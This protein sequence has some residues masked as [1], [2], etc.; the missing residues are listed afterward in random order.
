MFHLIDVSHWQNPA[1]L[2][3]SGMRAAGCDGVIVRLTYG[4]AHDKRAR[5]HIQ[6]ARDVGMAVGAY[7]FARCSQGIGDQIDAFATAARLAGYGKPEDL[8]PVLDA[9]D[10]TG[11]RPIGPENAG[12]F[13][14]MATLL[15]LS[16]GQKPYLYITQRD[17]GRLGKPAFALRLPL[18]VAH[19]AAP[20]RIEPATPNGAPWDLWQCAVKDFSI[21]VINGYDKTAKLPLDQNRARKLRF[22][23]GEVFEA[24]LSRDEEFPAERHIEDTDRTH[25]KRARILEEMLRT[26]AQHHATESTFANLEALRLE[27]MREAA[28][29]VRDTDASELAPESERS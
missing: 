17:W 23:N 5:E 20:S 7:H 25:E 8:I 1:S 29:I 2:D 16:F 4:L 22:L 11:K 19:Y 18:F 3:W 10:D 26:E 15:E 28:G 9:E 12:A 27:G 24:T 13:E 14:T 6:R 21:P